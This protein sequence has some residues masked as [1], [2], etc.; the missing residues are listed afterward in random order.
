MALPC[1]R[2]RDAEQV[3]DFGPAAPI[4]ASLGD[5]RPE[6]SLKLGR[7]AGDHVQARRDVLRRKVASG[8]EPFDGGVDDETAV[9]AGPRS[10]VVVT[11]GLSGVPTRSQARVAARPN[12]A[13]ST[14]SSSR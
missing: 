4:L 2:P 14:T 6:P 8:A 11:P 13:A 7:Q 3:G 10:D 5:G 1:A 12:P 9:L